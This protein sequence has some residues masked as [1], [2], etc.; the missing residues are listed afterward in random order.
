MGGW[1]CVPVIIL[2]CFA[3]TSS[4]VEFTFELP[5]KETQCFFQDIEKD[6]DVIFEFQVITGGQY[7]VDVQIFSPDEAV[8]FSVAR[9]QF[10]R[11]N[12]KTNTTGTFK[13]CFSNEFSTFSHKV[14]YMDW[15]VGQREDM[16]VD[17]AKV[18]SF[19]QIS[20]SN[21]HERLKMLLERQTHIRLNAATGRKFAEDLNERVTWWSVCQTVI[22]VIIAVVQVMILKSFFSD[23]LRVRL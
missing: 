22:M 8:M 17:H 3:A 20:S 10:D 18:M 9:K 14:V 11:F 19:I 2:L 13:A 6:V 12:W 23:R 16:P 7:D 4:C 5:D 1:I 15:Q 21:M